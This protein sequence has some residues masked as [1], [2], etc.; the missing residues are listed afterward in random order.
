MTLIVLV[1]VLILPPIAKDVT[2][3]NVTIKQK[4]MIFLLPI[5]LLT[6][7]HNP[8]GKGPVELERS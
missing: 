4:T 3:T 1:V 7:E 2:A 5:F 8:P 6:D